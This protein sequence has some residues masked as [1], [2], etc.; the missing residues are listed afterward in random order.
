MGKKRPWKLILEYSLGVLILFLTILLAW[1][2]PDWY[3]VWKD[4][5][6]LGKVTVNTRE[7]MKF[8]NKDSL[9]IAGKMQLLSKK[10][11]QEWEYSTYNMFNPENHLE[12]CTKLLKL[13]AKNGLLPS[14]LQDLSLDYQAYSVDGS[15]I[16]LGDQY[17]NIG[18]FRFQTMLPHYRGQGVT[19]YDEIVLTVLMDLESDLLYYVSISGIGEII[20]DYFAQILGY[21]SYGEYVESGGLREEDYSRYDFAAVCGAQSAQIHRLQGTLELDVELDY[22]NVTG[23]AYRIFIENNYYGTGVAFLFGTYYWSSFVGQ[24]GETYGYPITYWEYQ[25]DSE[26][27]LGMPIIFEENSTSQNVSGKETE[28]ALIPE[29]KILFIGDDQEERSDAAAQAEEQNY[30]SDEIPAIKEQELPVTVIQDGMS[31]Q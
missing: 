30:S 14:E 3:N 18:L 23:H 1:F 31:R 16:N 26:Y 25:V 24:I 15:M 9:D 6:S 5:G 8:L 29:E 27:A 17:L 10:S 13:W 11:E 20:Y 19:D 4:E 2:A 22:G 7:E 12:R 28:D 21:G